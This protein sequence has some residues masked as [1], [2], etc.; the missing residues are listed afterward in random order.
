M[1]SGGALLRTILEG[2][3]EVNRLNNNIMIAVDNLTSLYL[4]HD[5]QP[6]QNWYRHVP[7]RRWQPAAV[8][9][10][11]MP[12]PNALQKEM[13]TKTIAQ[14]KEATNRLT[15]EK[16]LKY[17]MINNMKATQEYNEMLNSGG[18]KIMKKFSKMA[19]GF[20]KSTVGKIAGN[21]LKYKAYDYI[22]GKYSEEQ[23]NALFSGV[24]KVEGKKPKGGGDQQQTGDGGGNKNKK[25]EQKNQN[26]GG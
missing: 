2:E 14:I 22:R 18:D 25:K 20:S 13:D 16:E 3:K 23:A 10:H 19:K 21:A 7:E 4:Q 15:A 17:A 11:G 26:G 12:D 6:D 8:Y 5:G 9:A 24:L 1:V